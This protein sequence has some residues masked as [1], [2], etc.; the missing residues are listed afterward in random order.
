MNRHVYICGNESVDT[1]NMPFRLLPLLRENFPDLQFKSFDPTENFPEDNP[2]Y[3]IDVVLGV[4]KVVVLKDID[5]FEDAPHVSVH[6]ADLG[7]HLKWLR[8]IGKCPEVFIFGVPAEGERLTILAD[9]NSV[10]KKYAGV[11]D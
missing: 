4:K 2:L 8:K 5:Q 3:I 1:D 9:L 11:I 7:F 10:L 6:D